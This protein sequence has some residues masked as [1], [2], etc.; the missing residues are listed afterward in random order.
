MCLAIPMKIITINGDEDRASAND[1]E[2]PINLFL[3]KDQ[4]IAVGYFV[5]VHV[6]YTVQK[7]DQED[8]KRTCQLLDSVTEMTILVQDDA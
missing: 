7:L 3:V 1:I 2:H 6:G 8:A 4:G 5:V